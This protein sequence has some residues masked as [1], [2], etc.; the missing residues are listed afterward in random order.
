[1]RLHSLVEVRGKK[2][3]RM[4]KELHHIEI[5]GHVDATKDSPAWIV[6]HDF[7]EEHEPRD[8]EFFDHDEMLDHVRQH[9]GTEPVIEEEEE[10]Y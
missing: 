8:H 5:H 3:A 1:M 2:R 6:R 7:G 4:K 9:T 10:G